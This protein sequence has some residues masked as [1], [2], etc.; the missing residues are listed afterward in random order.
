MIFQLSKIAALI[1]AVIVLFSCSEKTTTETK[2]ETSEK[3][4]PV[5]LN[6]EKESLNIA[7]INND[8]L[9]VNYQYSKD[10]DEKIRRKERSLMANR[11]EVM[12][13][14][15]EFYQTLNQKAPTMTQFEAQQAEQL[16]M[17]KKEEIDLNDQEV[18]QNYIDWKTKILVNYQAHLDSTLENFRIKNNIDILIPSGGGITKF[19]YNN[20]L[21][22]TQPLVEYLNLE[23][24]KKDE[25]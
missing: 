14:F 7:L 17:K 10:I 5:E 1:F 21:D 12:A 6:N 3:A 4:A 25:D 11:E 18:Q 15:Q 24:T 8:S 19:Y 16:L 2:P 22:I 9:L 23:Y 20:A 13:E